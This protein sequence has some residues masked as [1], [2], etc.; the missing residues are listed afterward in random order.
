MIAYFLKVGPYESLMPHSGHS[1]PSATGSAARP[2]LLR[3]ARCLP[4]IAEHPIPAEV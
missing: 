4:V 3:V 1:G 2:S